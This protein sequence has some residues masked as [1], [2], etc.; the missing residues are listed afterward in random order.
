MYHRS[1]DAR[2]VFDEPHT[3]DECYVTYDEYGYRRLGHPGNSRVNIALTRMG[4]PPCR[5]WQVV[6]D[7]LDSPPRYRSGFF[8]EKALRLR[9]RVSR[10]DFDVATVRHDGTISTTEGIVDILRGRGLSI[11]YEIGTLADEFFLRCRGRDELLW[12]RLDRGLLTR[13]RLV[14]PR[15]E[16]L[17]RLS[18]QVCYYDLCQLVVVLDALALYHLLKDFRTVVLGG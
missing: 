6:V 18:L 5:C 13:F 10:F 12:C 1:R 14:L 7:R 2:Y 3:P 11:G 9:R 8:I 4:S 15:G 16:L 17:T